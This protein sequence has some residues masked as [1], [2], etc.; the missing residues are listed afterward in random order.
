MRVLTVQKA[1]R[2]GGN[3][4]FMYLIQLIANCGL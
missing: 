1:H 3:A 2:K 4:S